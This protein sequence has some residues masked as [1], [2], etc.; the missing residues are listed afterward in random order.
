MAVHSPQR[1]QRH[2]ACNRQLAQARPQRQAVAMKPVLLSVAAAL[3]LSGCVA[4][5]GAAGPEGPPGPTGAIG[6]AGAM[7]PT[8]NAPQRLAVQRVTASMTV[9]DAVDII[10]AESADPV[11][12]TLPRAVDAGLGRTIT[13]RALGRG[14]VQL[15]AS[16]G[17]LIDRA[18]AFALDADEMVTVIS[19]GAGRWTIIAS[20]DL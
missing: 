5:I 14:R 12:V 15:R 13:V 4:S 2:P 16:P 20:S 7:G 1:R 8:N 9:P 6:P 17:E 18:A 19:D 3:L 10:I 11:T